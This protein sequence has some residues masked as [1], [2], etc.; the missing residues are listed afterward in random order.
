M[1]PDMKAT[2]LFLSGLLP[3]EHKTFF[4]NFTVVLDELNVEWRLLPKTSDIW[5]R[6][7]MPVPVNAKKFIQF[8]F[9]PDY[10]L[11]YEYLWTDPQAVCAM[12]SFKAIQS[13]LV[14]DGGN[15][16]SLK[17]KL[18]CTDKIY[19]ENNKLSELEVRAKL[20]RCLGVD[21][22]IVIPCEPFDI[23]GHA[24][25]MLRFIDENTVL[26]NDYA[27]FLPAFD[28]ELLAVLMQYD[29]KV[30]FLPYRIFD[31][32]NR[33]GIPSAKGNYS[34][35][36][37]IGNVIILPKYGIEEDDAALEKIQELFP[38]FIIRT[39]DCNSIAKEGGVL[40]C[41]TWV[42]GRF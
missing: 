39:L 31:R 2:T 25:G 42:A 27:P 36:L 18:I 10:L 20:R 23:I 41:I 5:C 9:N 8:H 14:V 4:K 38:G 16:V 6:D 34:N 28:L 40:N 15:I 35:F 24:D 21:E 19:S 29:L 1:K 22:V 33:D 7:Y 37:Q 30:E 13:D 3:H 26:V 12:L 11:G 17:K 32:V